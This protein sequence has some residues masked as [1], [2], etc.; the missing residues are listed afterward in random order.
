MHSDMIA[1]VKRSDAY[2]CMEVKSVF[3][4][5][6]YSGTFL[7]TQL[8]YYTRRNRHVGPSTP[9]REKK[10]ENRLIS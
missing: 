5:T 7:K 9:R 1:R 6:L 10:I 3:R 8:Q 4:I 2:I